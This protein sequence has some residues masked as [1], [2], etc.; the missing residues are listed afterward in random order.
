MEMRLF[1]QASKP[2]RAPAE[3]PALARCTASCPFQLLTP[4]LDVLPTGALP[5]HLAR[6][7]MS[8]PLLP[9]NLEFQKSLFDFF[10]FTFCFIV[11]GWQCG[12]LQK[13]VSALGNFPLFG[14]LLDFRCSSCSQ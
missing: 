12:E 4:L 14:G 8:Q 9:M 5:F 10:P 13:G 1:N 11:R 2:C 6:V 7:A 3:Q